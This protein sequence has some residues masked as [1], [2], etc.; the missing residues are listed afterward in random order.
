M[1]HFKSDN[2]YIY[3]E[4]PYME[5]YVPLEYFDQ[6]KR[7]A[8]D[9]SSY[10]NVLG[11]FSVGIFKD[12]KVS[13]FKTLKNPY[14]I[15]CYVYESEIRTVDIPHIGEIRC[16]VISYNKGQKVMDSQIVEDSV[17]G[18]MFLNLMINGKLPKSC[19]YDK[20]FDLWD[21][22]KTMNS[23]D[24]GVRAEV[25]EMIVSLVYRT[26]GKLTE[27]FAKTFGAD[28]NTDPYQ[29]DMVDLRKVCQYASTFSA[30]T[31]EDFDTMVTT[32]INRARNKTPEMYTP[33]EE[34]IKM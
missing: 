28:K 32:S 12:G 18:L 21:K 15:K 26:K 25:E 11:I 6:T 7:F 33:I 8:E 31:F 23:V 22:N 24:F 17:N 13:E 5:F 34:T 29:Y 14:M 2:K 20:V 4:D 16:K 1:S 3:L 10:I 9:Y 30:I 19:P 27:K